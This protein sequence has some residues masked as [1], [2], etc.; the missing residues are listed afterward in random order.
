[1][2]VCYYLEHKIQW[3]IT[4]TNKYSKENIIHT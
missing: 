4:I 2:I 3:I 1:M